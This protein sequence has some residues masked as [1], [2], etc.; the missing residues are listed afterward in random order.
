[1]PRP[2]TYRTEAIVLRRT[3]FGEADRLL[4]LYS[5]EHGKLRAI[6]KGARKPQSRKTGHV[7]LFMRTSFLIAKGTN[8]DIVTQAEVV[9][10]YAAL[11]EDL[12]R[13]T[14]AS[15]FV[16][17]LDSFAV[18]GDADARKYT[19]LSDA[20]SWIAGDNNLLLAARAYELRLLALAGY[21]PQLFRCAS[22][23]R[24][25]EEG[26]YSFSADLGGLLGEECQAADRGARPASAAAVKALRYLQ[27]RSWEAVGGV[28]LKGSLN[29]E[30][31]SLMHNYL[32]HILERNLKSVEFLHRLRREA[33][34]L[35]RPDEEG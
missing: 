19:L 8:L 34:M 27:C 32:R 20:L 5:R 24:P 16:E 33:A 2:R 29:L 9:E 11:R 10:P 6:A 31:E 35:A 23:G 22:C 4:T 21:Q 7:E 13:T 18:E 25:L 15:Y 28:R 12:G 30:L 3:D 1:M 26:A 17:L 14:Y